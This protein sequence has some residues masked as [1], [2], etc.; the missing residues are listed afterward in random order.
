MGQGVVMM[1]IISP[2]DR[3]ILAADF[4]PDE[5]PVIGSSLDEGSPEHPWAFN[6]YGS[7]GHEFEAIMQYIMDTWDYAGEGR[8]PRIGHQ[9]W[10]L[11]SGVFHHDGIDRMLEWYPEKFDFVAWERAPMGTATWAGEIDKLMDCDYILF[12]TVGT[13]TS[14][15]IKEARDRGYEGALFGGTNS[16]PGYWDMVEAVLP[17]EELY[18]CY[19][20]MWTPWWSDEALDFIQGVKESVEKYHGGDPARLRSSGPLS[21]WQMGLFAVDAL[22]R[23]IEAVGAENL[24][25][26]AIRDAFLATNM[27][28]GGFGESWEFREGYHALC[29]QMKMFEWNQTEADWEDIGDPWITPR[30]LQ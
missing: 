4:G 11:A 12:S 18:D 1:S 24:D 7:N 30:S 10:V 3:S 29:R 17:A 25:G 9:S 15:F 28:V 21:G 16:F 26:P 23:A 19:C 20:A 6:A 22:K 13:M 27:T 2:T 5:M 14:T 8:N